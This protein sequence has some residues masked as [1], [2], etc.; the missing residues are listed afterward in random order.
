MVLTLAGLQMAAEL[1]EREGLL[2]GIIGDE[3]RDER[4]RLCLHAL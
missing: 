1:R 3:V 4:G 2:I